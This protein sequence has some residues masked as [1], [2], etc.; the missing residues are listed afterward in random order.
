MLKVLNDGLVGAEIS[1]DVSN[2]KCKELFDSTYLTG[3]TPELDAQMHHIKNNILFRSASADAVENTQDAELYGKYCGLYVNKNMD[4][5]V[6][7]KRVLSVELPVAANLMQNHFTE[8]EKLAFWKG[9]NSVLPVVYKELF[10]ELVL[11]NYCSV[12]VNELSINDEISVAS[13][14]LEKYKNLLISWI[15]DSSMIG[16]YMDDFAYGYV[17]EDDR[18]YN[19]KKEITFLGLLQKDELGKMLLKHYSVDTHIY[20]VLLAEMK[21][22]LYWCNGLMKQ[23]FELGTCKNALSEICL[24]V[25]DTVEGTMYE[26]ESIDGSEHG[27]I[28]EAWVIENIDLICN[29]EIIGGKVCYKKPTVDVCEKAKDAKFSLYE[30]GHYS[31]VVVH[32]NE[33][34]EDIK[35]PRLIPELVKQITHKSS[36]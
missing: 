34:F 36:N 33:E 2:V 25:I 21:H 9:F 11:E 1:V 20:R 28:D 14:N 12:G 30:H 31:N 17:E 26:V 4:R 24:D 8:Y 19:Y 5:M 29:A 35:H 7:C 23:I 18:Y 27:W 22:K 15:A 16:M 32:P 6:I 13:F 3:Y 10:S